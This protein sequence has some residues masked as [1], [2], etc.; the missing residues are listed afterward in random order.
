MDIY[1]KFN[2]QDIEDRQIDTFIG[3]SKGL[4]A[5]GRI[6]QKEALEL[7]VDKGMQT[8]ANDKAIIEFATRN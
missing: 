2:R 3:L 6:N 7:I 4:I 8:A 5:D 1:T